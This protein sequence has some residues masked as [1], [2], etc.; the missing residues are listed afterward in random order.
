[1]AHKLHAPFSPFPLQHPH[2]TPPLNK[3]GW[4]PFFRPSDARTIEWQWSYFIAIL[5]TTSSCC[6]HQH[7]LVDN[8]MRAVT[9]ASL[10][11]FPHHGPHKLWWAQSRQ[12][13]PSFAKAKATVFLRLAGSNNNNRRDYV[14]MVAQ[15]AGHIPKK[16][17]VV[18]AQVYP[19]RAMFLDIYT[20]GS[21]YPEFLLGI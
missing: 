17:M 6:R 10:R 19:I 3:C 2:P 4:H 14:A 1:M 9:Q 16:W 15:A 18:V 8:F 7:Q 13:E 20:E 21:V 5:F 11:V 12:R